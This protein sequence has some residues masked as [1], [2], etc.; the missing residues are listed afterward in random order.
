MNSYTM[1]HV[2]ECVCESLLST[3]RAAAINDYRALCLSLQHHH[4]SSMI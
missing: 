2:S 1:L 4:M 3:H